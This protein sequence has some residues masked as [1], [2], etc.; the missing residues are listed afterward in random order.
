MITSDG[1]S[2][3]RNPESHYSRTNQPFPWTRGGIHGTAAVNRDC[4][5]PSECPLDSLWLFRVSAIPPSFPKNLIPVQLLQFRSGSRVF[6]R[7]LVISSFSSSEHFSY[8]ISV[9]KLGHIL[10]HSELVLSAIDS[11]LENKDIV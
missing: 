8:R 10:A 3:T 7:S 4:H 9:E 11:C 2:K 5:R 6:L 1:R